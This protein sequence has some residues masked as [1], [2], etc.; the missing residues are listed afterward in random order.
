MNNPFYF[1]G[2]LLHELGHARYLIDLYGMNVHDD[3]SG[4][5]VAITENGQLIVGTPYMPLQGGAVYFTPI[6]GLM[7]GQYTFIDEYSTAAFNLISGH[8][9]ILGNYNSPGNIGV[10]LQDLPSENQI[11]LKNESGNILPGADVK[12]YQA[13]S[14]SGLWYGKYYDDIPD[15]HL[16]A[17]SNGVVAVGRCPFSPNG[18]IV[19]TYGLSNSVIII[20]VEQNGLVGYGFMEVTQ[21]NM[22]YWRGNTILGSY[23]MQFTLVDPSPIISQE[24]K[25]VIDDFALVQNYPNPFNPRTTIEYQV[26]RQSDVRL[27]VFNSLGERI[28]ILISE[29][30]QPAGFYKVHWD[31]TDQQGREVATGIY[32]YQLSAGRYM[33]NRKMILIR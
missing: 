2:S 4:T 5:T 3:G 32:L 31:G 15:L 1:E 26:P 22:E 7:N 6:N 21:F 28:K 13:T 24:P 29:D 19:H 25:S 23:E 14:Q 27:T 30:N 18:T 11:V 12:I 16:T 33:Q 9:A 20:R 8:R 17:D 10:F